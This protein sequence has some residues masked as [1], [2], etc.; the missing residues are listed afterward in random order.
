MMSFEYLMK[1]Q[2]ALAK[3]IY[4][5]IINPPEISVRKHLFVFCVPSV[6]PQFKAKGHTYP[7]A[8]L[9]SAGV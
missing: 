9:S 3:H 4:E 6:M 7:L 8:I 1:A 2:L 5:A